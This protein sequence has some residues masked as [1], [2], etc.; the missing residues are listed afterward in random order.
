MRNIEKYPLWVKIGLWGY[1]KRSSIV[2]FAW[3]GTILALPYI[4]AQDWKMGLLF[5][6]PVCFACAAI[7]WIDKND[8]W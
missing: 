1:R 3:L 8:R 2:A 5:G 6:V 7:N 4:I